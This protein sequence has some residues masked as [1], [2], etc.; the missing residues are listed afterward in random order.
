MSITVFSIIMNQKKMP[1]EV[2]FRVL[3][4]TYWV[5]LLN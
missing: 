3:V 4:N 5:V 1:L 2:Y